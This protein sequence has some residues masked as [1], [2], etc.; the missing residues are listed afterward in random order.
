MTDSMEDTR[1][2]IGNVFAGFSFN[3]L[4]HDS[5]A[6]NRIDVSHVE[7]P[8]I[9]IYKN[10]HS[11]VHRYP[12]NF[13]GT[14]FSLQI[15]SRNEVSSVFPE[16]TKSTTTTSVT[17]SITEKDSWQQLPVSISPLSKE[18]VYVVTPQTASTV[19]TSHD[20]T[21]NISASLHGA[22]ED[23]NKQP[24]LLKFETIERAYQVLPQAVN[25]LAVA[26]TGPATIPLWGIME[27][28]VYAT[29]VNQTTTPKSPIHYAG[30]SKV[31][32]SKTT[33]Y[34]NL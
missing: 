21:E 16:E 1:K 11:I 30:H 9:C 24:D 25:N 33:V 19:P 32:S 2:E 7:V 23:P 22:S 13:N 20:R 10:D 14:D 17:A 3:D 28:E 18:R 26:S 15:S 29:P 31:R 4:E 6:S 34:S 27:H 5:S 12:V 8:N